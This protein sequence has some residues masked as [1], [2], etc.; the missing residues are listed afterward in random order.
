[1]GKSTTQNRFFLQ[2]RKETEPELF[3]FCV[4]T[5][6]PSKILTHS[7]PQNGRLNLSFVKDI[8]EVGKNWLEMVVTHPF[9]SRKFW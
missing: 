6:E 3:E 2:N 5:F 9:D 7:T 4:I 1:M 8:Y